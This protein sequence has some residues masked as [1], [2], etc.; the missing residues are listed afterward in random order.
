MKKVSLII[1]LL[2]PLIISAQ[3]LNSFPLS[4]AAQR[5]GDTISTCGKIY[6][7]RYIER[8][9]TRLTLLSMGNTFP[10][11]LLT[12]VI[13]VDVRKKLNYKP[14]DSLNNQQICVTGKI[15]EFQG[16]PQVLI[17]KTEDIRIPT[18]GKDDYGKVFTKVEHPA[19]FPGGDQ[20][21]NEYV[22]VNLSKTSLKQDV[23]KDGVHLVRVSFI[24]DIY[25]NVSNVEALDVP[26]TCPV[27]GPEAVKLI[28]RGPK[29]EPAILNYHKVVYQVVQP[30]I[31]E[32][33]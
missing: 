4:Q 12:V 26:K 30:V 7:V 6:S 5:I 23:I 18:A 33:H 22:K 14:E 1:I 24:V 3:R 9:N 32:V 28:K 16:K 17:L 13:P 8:G 11:Q 25:G 21:F 29:W 27:C 15:E 2:F 31:F 10:N 19:S 20:A